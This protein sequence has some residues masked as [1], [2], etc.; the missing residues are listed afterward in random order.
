[1][2]TARIFMSIVPGSARNIQDREAFD[3]M[4]NRKKLADITKAL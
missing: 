2:K 4:S 3:K 1:M